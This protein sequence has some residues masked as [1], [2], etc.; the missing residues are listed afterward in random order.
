MQEA[1]NS[2]QEM[3]TKLIGAFSNRRQEAKEEV[4]QGKGYVDIENPKICGMTRRALG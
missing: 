2:E 3:L 4:V 1:R